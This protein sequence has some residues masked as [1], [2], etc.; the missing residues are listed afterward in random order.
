MEYKANLVMVQSWVAIPKYICW[1][2]WLM[3]NHAIFQNINLDLIS[4]V[5]KA[6]QLPFKAI[7]SIG[8]DPD[9]LKDLFFEELE[10]SQTV[11]PIYHVGSFKP[12]IFIPSFAITLQEHW[13]ESGEIIWE[14]TNYF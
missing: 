3:C 12:Q 8:F 5:L 13:L 11:K 2:I 4:L 9:D 1:S 6:S 14:G 7:S 10:W